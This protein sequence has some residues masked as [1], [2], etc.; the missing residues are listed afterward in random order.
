MKGMEQIESFAIGEEP[1]LS[2]V[3]TLASSH[4][5]AYLTLSKAPSYLAIFTL[6]FYLIFVTLK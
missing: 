6:V 1:K 5:V 3:F 4:H 2:P